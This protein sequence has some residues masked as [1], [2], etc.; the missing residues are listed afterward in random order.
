M[1]V[2]MN[3]TVRRHLKIS[4][5]IHGRYPRLIHLL[6]GLSYNEKQA[7]HIKNG[8]HWIEEETSSRAIENATE[9]NGTLEVG[10]TD[11]CQ[12]CRR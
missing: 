11:R 1:L 12:S 8:T 7:A 5:L 10:S 3:L 6:L 4:V 9:Q 2:G